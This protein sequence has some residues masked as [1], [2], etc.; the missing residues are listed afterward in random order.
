MTEQ[1]NIPGESAETKTYDLSKMSP[2]EIAAIPGFDLVQE[3]VQ[4]TVEKL[5][6]E[7]QE[8]IQATI[9][10]SLEVLGYTFPN[11]VRKEK[12]FRERMGRAIDPD[13]GVNYIILDPGTENEVL[14]VQFNPKTLQVQ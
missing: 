5:T 9:D 2:E 11:I 14:L 4:A 3:R 8:K 6:N 13:T 10:T 1:E 12:F 7:F